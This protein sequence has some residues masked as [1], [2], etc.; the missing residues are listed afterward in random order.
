MQCGLVLY[1]SKLMSKKSERIVSLLQAKRRR[2]PKGF[3]KY[4]PEVSDMLPKSARRPVSKSPF[5]LTERERD[6]HRDGLEEIPH[7]LEG[8]ASTDQAI[9]A[10]HH[11]AMLIRDDAFYG[12]LEDGDFKALV[13]A[14]VGKSP[15]SFR[16]KTTIKLESGG[17]TVEQVSALRGVYLDLD[18]ERRLV[19]ITIHPGK[20]REHRRLMKVV[21]IGADSKSDVAARHDEYLAMQD[22]HGR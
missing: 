9:R 4:L 11:Y 16:A 12:E 18:G 15:G 22:P 2:D 19:S 6:F 7:V 14:V 3:R 5:G 17:S 1:W 13:K 10:L 20:M 8:G 21:G